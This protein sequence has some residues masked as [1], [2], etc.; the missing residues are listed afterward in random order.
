MHVV[1]TLFVLIDF[2]IGARPVHI[3]HFIHPTIYG[4]A[5]I[6]FSV[7][8]WTQNHE[9]NII[10][11]VLDWN[12]PGFAVGLVC[13]LAFVIIPTMQIVY[14]GLY[15]LRL[16]VFTKIYK[17]SYFQDWWTR[18]GLCAV[19]FF[20]VHFVPY[21]VLQRYVLERYK[22]KIQAPKIE[23]FVTSADLQIKIRGNM[24]YGVLIITHNF[25]VLLSITVGL[26]LSNRRRVYCTQ[27][28]LVW[29]CVCHQ[30][31]NISCFIGL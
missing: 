22:L 10:Y 7:I 6:I 31:Y 28:Y 15:H 13:V 25:I 12:S 21:L 4:L 27:Y 3:L 11:S 9:K 19:V 24:T 1:N 5:Y 18:C 23:L 16:R 20:V 30:L 17:T 26:T 2:C 29:L 8:F 14:F